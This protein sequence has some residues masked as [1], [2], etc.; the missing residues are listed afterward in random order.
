MKMI[1]IVTLQ[2]DIHL[3]K[4]KKKDITGSDVKRPTCLKNA[5]F[6]MVQD[7]PYLK[8]DKKI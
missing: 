2:V 3:C 6:L 7:D 4:R 8:L 1:A 5:W